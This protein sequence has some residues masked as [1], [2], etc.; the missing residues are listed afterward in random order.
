MI[1]IITTPTFQRRMN[2]VSTLWINV[3]IT[4]KMKQN[5][6]TDFQHCLKLIHTQSPTL[7]ERRNNVTQ[8]YYS[9]GLTL[10]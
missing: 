10:F 2:V 9:I 7:K 3:E 5:P 1:V 8:H 6:T 4:M